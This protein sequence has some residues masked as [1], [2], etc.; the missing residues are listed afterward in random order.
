MT[1]VKICGQTNEEDFDAVVGS[2]AE[3]VGFISGTPNS[4]RNLSMMRAASLISMVTRRV[5]R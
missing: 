5:A 1:R 3:A 2:G 4:P